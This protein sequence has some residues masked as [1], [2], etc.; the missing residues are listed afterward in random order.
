M[1]IKGMDTL[2][3]H[4]PELNS[5]GGR[6]CIGLYVVLLFSLTTVYF[7]YTDQIPTWSI[8]S[9]IVIMSLGF[10]LLY[11][12]FSL[13]QNYKDKY[14][15]LAYRKAFARF[16]VPGLA[17]IF[18]AIAHA[19][20]MNGPYVPTG[21]WTTI[22]IALGWFMVVI[23][24]A[25]WL[26]SALTFG[27]DYLA[28]LYLYHPHESRIVNSSIYDILRHPIYAGAMRVC[29]GLALL[30][31]NANALAF[32]PFLPLG[33]FGW[34]RLVEEKELIERFGQTYLAYRKNVPAFMP[35]L[36]D[37]GKFFMFLFKGG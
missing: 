36:K 4:V 26:R 37:M 22:F 1:N 7:I 19:G 8:D 18:A 13:K 11:L 3:K 10:L 32:I 2:S 27:V 20:Y 24:G 6:L 29:I 17:L 23:G 30:N 12:C 16:G 33:F 14:K 15:E 34:V 28:F 21:W 35:R 9:Q 31:G 5:G 25:L